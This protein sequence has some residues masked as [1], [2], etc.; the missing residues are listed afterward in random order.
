[1]F[2]DVLVGVVV[3]V[4][5]G[6]LVGTTGVFVGVGVGVVGARSN[7]KFC[8]V[9]PPSVTTMFDAVAVLYPG[10]LAVIV[11]YVPAGMFTNE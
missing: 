11:G 10:K 6:V 9:M 5:V 2:V 1:M 3:G 8:E 7:E 4:R